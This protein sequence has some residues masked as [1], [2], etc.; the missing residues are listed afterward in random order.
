MTLAMQLNVLVLR[1]QQG[2]GE[3]ATLAQREHD[4]GPH[5]ACNTL[6]G[7]LNSGVVEFADD[8]PRTFL[9]LFVGGL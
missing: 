5:H 2:K 4:V 3:L 8:R 1:L 6:L 9:L 7:P